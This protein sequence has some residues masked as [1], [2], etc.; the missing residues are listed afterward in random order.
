MALIQVGT[1]CHPEGILMEDLRVSWERLAASLSLG[2]LQEVLSRELPRY[3]SD[4]P[5]LAKPYTRAALAQAVREA[6][7]SAEA[8][9]YPDPSCQQGYTSPQPSRSLRQ[10]PTAAI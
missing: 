2:T 4:V 9:V 7:E 8:P 6:L 10:R 3:C 1:T 5:W